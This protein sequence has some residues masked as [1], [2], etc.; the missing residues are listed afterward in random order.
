MQPNPFALTEIVAG[1]SAG[2][3]FYTVY[4]PQAVVTKLAPA[5]VSGTVVSTLE[6]KRVRR[7]NSADSAVIPVFQEVLHYHFIGIV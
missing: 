5:L 4:H 3:M 2:I 7:L 6:R 1:I